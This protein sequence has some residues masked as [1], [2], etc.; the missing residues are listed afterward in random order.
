LKAFVTEC[1]SRLFAATPTAECKAEYS[2]QNCG[3]PPS[4]LVSTLYGQ[5]SWYARTNQTETQARRRSIMLGVALSG[6][7]RRSGGGAACELSSRPDA[8]VQSLAFLVLPH[9]GSDVCLKESCSLQRCSSVK[10]RFRSTF[11]GDAARWRACNCA[12]VLRGGRACLQQSDEC[13]R[14][15]GAKSRVLLRHS[16]LVVSHRLSKTYAPHTASTPSLA[17]ICA[18]AFDC[19]TFPFPSLF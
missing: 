18:L 16:G 5:L 14:G 17:T 7:A 9:C 15:G 11:D 13:I 1:G 12:S 10:A 8:H 3:I 6:Q 2:N 4:A 19:D